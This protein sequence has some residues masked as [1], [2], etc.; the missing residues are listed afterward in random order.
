MR[1]YQGNFICGI[2]ALG[3]GIA[4]GL[5]IPHQ[6]SDFSEGYNISGRT[7]PYILALVMVA[8]G[9]ALTVISLVQRHRFSKMYEG[10]PTPPNP[11]SWGDTSASSCM[12]SLSSST[13]LAC[14]MSASS[15]QPSLQRSLP[16]S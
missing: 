4:Y 13:R 1:K 9:L 12:F 15:S 3:I 5:S 11:V 16:C 8:C 6:V 10:V 14:A 7:L 2:T